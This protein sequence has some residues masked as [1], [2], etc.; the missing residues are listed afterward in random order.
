MYHVVY[1]ILSAV[2]MLIEYCLFKQKLAIYEVLCAFTYLVAYYKVQSFTILFVVYL[3]FSIV[4]FWGSIQ[5]G[6]SRKQNSILLFFLLF[7]LLRGF[8]FESKEAVLSSFLTR[9]VPI[10]FPFL[11]IPDEKKMLKGNLGFDACQ[12]LLRIYTALEVFLTMFLILVQHG[13]PEPLV[14]F[15]QP[16]G[17][18]IAIAGSFMLLLLSKVNAK[19]NKFENTLIALLCIG[20]TLYSKTRGFIVV[21]VPC[22]VLAL[23]NYWTPKGK[24]NLYV[25]LGILALT[26]LELNL[27]FMG[28]SI[29]DFVTSETMTIGYRTLENKL[30]LLSFVQ[31]A[32]LLQ[33]LFG[34]GMG[35]KGSKIASATMI[36]EVGRTRFYINH[37]SDLTTLQNNWLTFLKD[38]GLLGLV[39]LVY[40]YIKSA[41]DCKKRIDEKGKNAV[42]IYYAAFAFMLVYR[43]GCTCSVLEM[44]TPVIATSIMKLQ[45]EL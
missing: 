41:S 31:E 22:A 26:M 9:Y 37:L 18:N 4:P 45:D 13:I 21:A 42:T 39:A 14:V 7:E 29:L 35:A 24:R 30:V 3:V 36:N 6:I 33:I 38:I 25:F 27:Q 23:L 34:F 10:L 16:V 44:L 15:H 28:R 5:K 40:C 2:A 32:N 20:I 1:I 8:L 11:L 19:K 12:L 43:V 17:G